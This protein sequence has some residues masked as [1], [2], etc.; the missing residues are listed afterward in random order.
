MLSI[1]NVKKWPYT[2]PLHFERSYLQS[3]T[4]IALL[5]FTKEMEVDALLSSIYPKL[6]TELL[7]LI[8]DE[9]E[10]D[11][12]RSRQIIIKQKVCKPFKKIP[13]MVLVN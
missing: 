8:L 7:M 4:I 13:P 11:A 6:P 5:R 12:L 1:K 9:I 10:N 3:I 2:P